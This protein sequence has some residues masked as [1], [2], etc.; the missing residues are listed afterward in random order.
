MRKSFINLSKNEKKFL[1]SLLEDGSKTDV[2]ISKETGIS[3]ASASR[4]R[5]KL[6]SEKII[7]EYIPIVD[8]DLIGIDVFLVF[9]FQWKTFKDD[10][11]TSQIMR[12][13]ESDPNVVFLAN[14]EGSEGFTTCVFLGFKNIEEYHSYFKKFRKKYENHIGKMSTLLIPSKE[15]IKHD[16][17]DITMKILRRD[18]K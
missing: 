4:I 16:F 5:K 17:T 7:A 1:I 9:L 8:L 3:K 12:E 11:L 14:G 10:K 13:L 15:I 18:D 6:E 2:Q